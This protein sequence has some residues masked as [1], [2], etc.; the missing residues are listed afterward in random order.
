MKK[1]ATTLMLTGV[2]GLGGMAAGVVVAPAI[3][4]AQTSDT[5]TAA[6]VSERV[7]RITE[8]L[9]GLVTDGSITQAQ[10]DEVATTLAEEFPGGR[11]GH[12][13]GHN[14][15]TAAEALGVTEDEL[16]T[17]LE[18]GQSM[19]D[20]AAAEGVDKQT[21][22]DALVAAKN[23]HLDEEVTEGELTQ[24]EADAKKADV[25]ENVTAQVEQDGLPQHHGRGNDNDDDDAADDAATDATA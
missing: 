7:T 3:A 6:A 10:A 19:A 13:G 22:I 11:G 14:L 15:D 18:G 20:V 25:V 21:L 4:M 24:A 23:A 2:L 8:A 5:S 1:R 17:A 16:R 12:G 9:S